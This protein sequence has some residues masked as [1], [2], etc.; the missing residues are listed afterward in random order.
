[1]VTA[2]EAETANPP[3]SVLPRLANVLGVSI[4]DLF[5]YNP[6]EPGAVLTDPLGRA[7]A[8]GRTRRKRAKAKPHGSFGARLADLRSARGLSQQELADAAG[9]SKRMVVYYEGQR[10]IAPWAALQGVARALRVSVDQLFGLKGEP[11]KD[12]PGDLRLWR[13]FR[14]VEKL[15]PR[16]RQAILRQ[17]RGL[18]RTTEE[19]ESTEEARGTRR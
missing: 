5:G 11:P 9:I 19:Q 3:G 14:L 1:M 8:R 15:S 7:E 13:R 18:L 4:D 6:A 10:T 12:V 2:Y 16:D 17:I